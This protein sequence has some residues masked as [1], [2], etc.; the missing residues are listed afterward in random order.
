[1]EDAMMEEYHRFI[2]SINTLNS[3]VLFVMGTMVQH[4]GMVG[5]VHGEVVMLR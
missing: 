1:M 5:Q 3:T 4:L 2:I